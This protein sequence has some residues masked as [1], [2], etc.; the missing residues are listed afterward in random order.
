MK[1]SYLKYETYFSEYKIIKEY[2]KHGTRTY[3]D[4]E[5]YVN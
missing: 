4:E 5:N 1:W 2:T 3:F